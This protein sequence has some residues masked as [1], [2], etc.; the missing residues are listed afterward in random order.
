M[1]KMLPMMK[2]YVD[3]V[4]NYDD[5]MVV[6]QELSKLDKFTT[7][8]EEQKQKSGMKLDLVALLITPVQ[9]VPR[10]ELLLRVSTK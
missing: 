3:Y 5:A 8:L 10:Y 2:L 9:R 6:F 7:W 1:L 4:N